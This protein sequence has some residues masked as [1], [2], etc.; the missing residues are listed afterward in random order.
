VLDAVLGNVGTVVAFRVGIQDAE[1]LEDFVSPLAT[2]RDISGLA[3]YTALVRSTAE[4]ASVP[5]TLAHAVTR[6]DNPIPSC[7]DS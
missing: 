6:T 4:F 3:N 2:A 5:F 7:R 1:L